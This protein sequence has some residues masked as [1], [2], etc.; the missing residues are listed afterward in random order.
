MRL[1][2]TI[3]IHCSASANG[4]WISPDQIDAWHKAPP[5]NFRRAPAFVSRY[6]PTLPHIGYHWLI[7]ADGVA[8]AGRDK[9]EIG[10]HVR[11]HNQNSIGI[12]MTGTDKFSEVQWQGLADL[13]C[14]FAYSWQD[15]IP[16]A[17]HVPF[18]PA[19]ALAI[20]MF[21]KMGVKIVGHRDL[22]PD[23]DGDGKIESNEWIKI[24][25]GFDVTD[26]LLHE[27]TPDVN[28]VAESYEAATMRIRAAAGG[29]A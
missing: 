10:A 17:A 25:P 18:K 8:R 12:C 21:E 27:M 15:R 5:N 28:H 4:V 2:N 22:S 23:L 26:W 9:E 29:V 7:T 1:I 13:L 24:C 19:P 14:T 16:A 20:S 3:V 11:N 6:R